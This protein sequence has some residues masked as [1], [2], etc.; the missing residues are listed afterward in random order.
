METIEWDVEL[1]EE[2]DHELIDD[3]AVIWGADEYIAV[4]STDAPKY[5]GPYEAN[6]LFSS[7]T[8]ETAQML[9]TDDF[10]V[11]AINYTEAPN[12]YGTTVTIGG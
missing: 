1:E 2:Y 11:R 7:Q 5:D 9:M 10:R 8:F 6:A 4:V 3:G 12:Q